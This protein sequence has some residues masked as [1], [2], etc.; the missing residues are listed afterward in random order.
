MPTI[1]AQDVVNAVIQDSQNQTTNRTTLYDYVDRI[2]QRIL[3]ESQWRF[4]LSDPQV[5]VTMPGVSSYTLISGT[6]PAGSFQTPLGLTDFNNIAPGSVFDLSTWTKIEEDSDSNT[7][8]NYIINR[9]G[10]LRSGQ[11]RTYSNSLL[12]PG[13]LLLKPTPDA[14]NSYYPIPETPVV[15]YEPLAGCGLPNRIYYGVATFVDN[16]G[17]E[18]TR[19]NV[20]FVIAIPAGCV[21]IVE[22][23]NAT[24][25]GISGDQAIYGCWNV[26]IGYSQGTWYRQNSTPITIGTSWVETI[27]GLNPGA[28]PVPSALYLPPV[29][30]SVLAITGSGFLTTTAYNTSQALPTFWGLQDNLG[31]V[32]Q[33]T[34][35]GSGQL[36]AVS[37]AGYTGTVNVLPYI[38]LT[39][40]SGVSTWKITVT[41]TGFLQAVLYSTPPSTAAIN[42]QPPQTSSIQP[43]NAYEIGRAHV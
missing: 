15:T 41:S 12:N 33:V 38:L 31:G 19:S 26:Y 23:P 4:L 35:S 10:S 13:T 14:Q 11:P 3:R 1:Q 7:S 25:G 30:N 27:Y 34:T 36:E 2:H 9:D 21:L 22:S 6:P 16:L 39:D 43:L 37:L 24:L 42:S 29:G 32:W 20:P 18:S 28:L 8:L 5:F 17:G 40:L